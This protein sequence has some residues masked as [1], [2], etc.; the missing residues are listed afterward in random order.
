MHKCEVCMYLNKCKTN[1]NYNESNNSLYKLTKNC[2]NISLIKL[3]KQIAR[4]LHAG[5]HV[6]KAWY[7]SLNF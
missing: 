5:S 2:I 1:S 4:R 3:E 6:F 7:K